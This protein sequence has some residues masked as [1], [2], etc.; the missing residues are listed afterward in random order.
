[1][2]FDPGCKFKHIHLLP[3]EHEI[4]IVLEG[5]G[6]YSGAINKKV[7]PGDIIE[8]IGKGELITIENTGKKPLR[9]LCINRPPWRKSHEEI[10]TE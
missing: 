4:E 2:E 8:Q 5:E 1:M 6:K 3:N 9:I 10:F 7:K